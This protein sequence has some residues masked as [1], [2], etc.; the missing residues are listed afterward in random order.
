L[1]HFGE[2]L[3][4]RLRAKGKQSHCNTR[5]FDLLGFGFHIW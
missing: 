5:Q 4:L 2:R 3:R 1:N